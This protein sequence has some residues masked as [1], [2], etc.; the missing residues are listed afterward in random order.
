M[1]LLHLFLDRSVSMDR[2]Y[3]CRFDLAQEIGNFL[4]IFLKTAW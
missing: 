3:G 4:A 1:V 2:Q